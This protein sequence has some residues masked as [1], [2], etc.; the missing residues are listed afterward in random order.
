M[1]S[2]SFSPPPRLIYRTKA[3]THREKDR[4]DLQSLRENYAEESFGDD[5]RG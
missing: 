1:A 2:R 4:A 5:N 3:K